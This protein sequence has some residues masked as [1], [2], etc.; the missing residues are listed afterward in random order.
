MRSFPGA[1]FQAIITRRASHAILECVLQAESQ[2]ETGGVLIGY[3]L[4]RIYLVAAATVSDPGSRDSRV[5]FVLDGA[6]H[7][8]KVKDILA[9]Y[10]L[11]PATLGIWH[12]HICDGHSFS[13]QDVDSNRIL[14]KRFGGIL[15]M[16]VTEREHIVTVSICCISAAG[17][18]AACKTTVCSKFK[19]E[20]TS[21]EWR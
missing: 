4:G 15:S 6:E 3:R 19:M 1:K 12:S 5:S 8:Q 9:G 10:K 7:T 2:H 21:H 18:E 16:L 13:A 20:V 14:A 11:R 17:V